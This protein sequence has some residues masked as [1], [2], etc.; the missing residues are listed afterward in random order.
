MEKP[1]GYQIRKAR[2]IVAL[3]LKAQGNSTLTRHMLSRCVAIMS[4]EEWRAVAFCAGV[5]VADIECRMA[6]LAI[7]RGKSLRRVA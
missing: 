2:E 4:D 1:N 3:L 6:V 5:P 7:L